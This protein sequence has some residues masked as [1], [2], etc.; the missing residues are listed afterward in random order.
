MI[1]E[2][3]TGGVVASLET[4]SLQFRE[5]AFNPSGTLLVSV[6]GNSSVELWEVR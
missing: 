1:W 2:V 4:P 5:L 3:A 6:D